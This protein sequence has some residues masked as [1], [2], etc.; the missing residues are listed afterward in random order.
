[1]TT[2]PFS[3][4]VRS[5]LEAVTIDLQGEINAFAEADLT[6]AYDEAEASNP[7]KILLNFSD[8]Y[9]IN[10]TGIA[11]IVGLLA[12]ARKA[13]RQI[14]VFGLSDHYMEIFQI[15]RLVDFMTVYADEGTALQ[16]L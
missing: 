11:L 10:S 14:Y 5:Q 8:V 12:R 6:A 7:S 4:Y 3:A 9:Y 1:M 15:T 2:K 16:S 13:H